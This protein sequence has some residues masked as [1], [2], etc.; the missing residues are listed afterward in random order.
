MQTIRSR[1]I[2][3]LGAL[4]AT[5]V[6][7]VAVNPAHAATFDATASDQVRHSTVSVAGIDMAS[8]GGRAILDRR[9]RTAATLVCGGIDRAAPRS[10]LLCRRQA[11]AD[12]R[13][14]LNAVTTQQ[15]AA[16]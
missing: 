1:T 6:S 14:S 5:S 3:A 15:L 2:A 13:A 7:I 12:A 4:L 8:P 16:R 10:F 9:I 11:I